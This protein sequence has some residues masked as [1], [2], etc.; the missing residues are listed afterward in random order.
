MC[1]NQYF[2]SSSLLSTIKL[3]FHVMQPPLYAYTFREPTRNQDESLNNAIKLLVA[4]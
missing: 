1:I 3:V 4:T 2:E